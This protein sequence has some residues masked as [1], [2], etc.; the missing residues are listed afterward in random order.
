M[1]ARNRAYQRDCVL[2]TGY[3]GETEAITISVRKEDSLFRKLRLS[4]PAIV[5]VLLVLM[6]GH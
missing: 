4:S 5:S 3:C 1:V 6:Q 2:E